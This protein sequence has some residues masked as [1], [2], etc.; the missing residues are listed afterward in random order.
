MIFSSLLFIYVF[1][2][3]SIIIYRLSPEKIRN[4]MLLIFSIVFC[5]LT[6]LRYL[7][8]ILVYTMIN[9]A[10]VKLVERFNERKAIAAVPL[11]IGIICDIASMLIFKT[12]Y[13]TD[14][15]EKAGFTNEFFPIGISFVMLSTIGCITDVYCG[16]IKEKIK[17]SD[18]MLYILFFPKLFMGPIINYRSFKKMINKRSQTIADIGIGLKL[19]ISG[20]SK[21]IIFAEILFRLYKSVIETET[22]GLSALTAWLGIVAYMLCLYFTLSAYSDMGSG[23][24]KCFGFNLS[25]SFNYPMFTMSVSNFCRRWHRQVILWFGK[26]IYKPIASAVSKKYIKLSFFVITWGIIGLWYEFSFNTF[27]WGLLIGI[28]VTIERIFHSKNTLKATSIIYTFLYMSLCT[29]FFKGDSVYDSLMYCFAM[30]GGNNNIVDSSA[31]YLLRSYSIII[32]VCIIVSS[33]FLR[34]ITERST[35]NAVRKSVIILSPLVTFM[36]LLICTTLISHN[37]IAEI[38]LVRL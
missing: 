30:I 34:K 26:Y 15:K 18:Y 9:Y 20:L 11:T 33:G 16:R 7:A 35:K 28:F 25:K 3:V 31:L 21:R 5:A 6:G 14:I 22:S 17:L 23:I 1:L 27:I 29:V 13:F 36:L 12:E 37:G 8:F 32:I 24:A 2:P 19:F 4:S 10:L 38:L